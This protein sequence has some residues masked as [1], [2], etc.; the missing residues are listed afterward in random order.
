MSLMRACLPLHSS[1]QPAEVPAVKRD[2]SAGQAQHLSPGLTGEEEHTRHT[3]FSLTNRAVK[4][5]TDASS[6]PAMSVSEI[7]HQSLNAF[8]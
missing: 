2:H 6:S 4:G 8:Y 1:H 7:T 5:E 3:L